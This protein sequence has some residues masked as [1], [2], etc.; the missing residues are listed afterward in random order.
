MPNTTELSDRVQHT[1]PDYIGLVEFLLQPFLENPES[2]SVDCEEIN[3][4]QKIWLRV[5][6][7][8]ADKGKV[9]GRGGR[10]IQAVRIVLNTAAA[11]AGQSV[12]LEIYSDE[13][14]KFNYTPKPRDNRN[15]P[16]RKPNSNNT[17]NN[18]HRRRFRRSPHQ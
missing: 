5:A 10:N 7:D 9:F 18:N 6:F 11:I 2:L 3:N 8:V 14:R 16:R 13:E 12:H 4:K 15:I 17:S 1:S